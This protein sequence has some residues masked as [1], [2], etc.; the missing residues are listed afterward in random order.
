MVRHGS[1]RAAVEITE[2]E[3]RAD[4]PSR[5]AAMLLGTLEHANRRSTPKP[6]DMQWAAGR[7]LLGGRCNQAYRVCD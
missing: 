4:K 2:R 1:A 3:P 5:R 6:T 7:W